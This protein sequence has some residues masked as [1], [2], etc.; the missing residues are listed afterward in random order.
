MLSERQFQVGD[1][2]SLNTRFDSHEFRVTRVT[3]KTA[4]AEEIPITLAP[5]MKTKPMLQPIRMHRTY[6]VREILDGWKT[7]A[8]AFIP[9]ARGALYNKICVTP[10]DNPVNTAKP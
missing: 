6:L 2:I 1:I 4:T 5:G 9:A 3:T 10:I 7:Y 8:I